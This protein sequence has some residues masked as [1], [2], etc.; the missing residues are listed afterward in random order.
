[1]SPQ[2]LDLPTLLAPIAGDNPAGVELRWEPIYD[3]IRRAR[4]E[5][6]RDMLQEAQ[7]VAAEW[8]RVMELA[9]G[10]LANRSKD[11][12][13]AAW[14]TEAVTAVHGFAGLRDGLQL[15][16]GLLDQYWDS[17]Y[18]LPDEG[19]LEPRVAPLVWLMD[20]DRGARLPN[21]LRDLPLTGDGDAI[22]SWNFWK[23]RYAP[24][25]GEAE[26]DGAYEQRKADAAGRAQEFE[27][28]VG[29]MP[30]EFIVGRQQEIQ[31]AR[32]ALEAFDRLAT[33]RF[34]DLA[35]PITPFRTSLDEIQVL[36]RRIV[37]DKGGLDAES[38]AGDAPEESP[39]ETNGAPAGRN[40]P[41]Q[42]RDDAFQRLAEVSAFLRRTEPQ[43]PVPLLIDR[44]ITWGRMPF[45]HLL[46]EMIKDESVRHQVTDLLGIQSKSED[47]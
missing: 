22:Y 9:S 29:R 23:S 34:G 5:D 37:R 47:Q 28:A 12:M 2:V 39:M 21:R 14:L 17:V 45:E 6:D 31:A 32:E 38:Q 40:G 30:V 8:P 33:Q 1:M 15:L 41:I 13:I 24:P 26:D 35:P 36:V 44:A 10:T 11:L 7:Q 19:D 18:P 4:S 16:C 27:E 46:R 25:K 3:E 20:A 43:S 42:S